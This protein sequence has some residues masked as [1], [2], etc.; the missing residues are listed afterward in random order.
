MAV[1]RFLGP[2]LVFVYW[3]TGWASP[4][5]AVA[6]RHGDIVAITAENQGLRLGT[7]S[8]VH[9]DPVTGARSVISAGGFVD[10]GLTRD[11]RFFAVTLSELVEVK[12][13]TGEIRMVRDLSNLGTARGLAVGPSGEL[14]VFDEDLA[15]RLSGIEAIDPLSGGWRISSSFPAAISPRS[16]RSQAVIAASFP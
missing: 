12:P 7:G 1:F 2:A 5:F 10:V 6:I 3:L 13:G 16:R 8:L 14:F 15:T 9:I 11:G 4:G